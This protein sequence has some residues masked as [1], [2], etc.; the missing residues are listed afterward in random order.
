MNAKRQLHEN[1]R[2]TVLEIFAI[3]RKLDFRMSLHTLHLVQG[4][5]HQRERL[6]GK[7]DYHLIYLFLSRGFRGLL[8]AL[9]S[10]YLQQQIQCPRAF[11]N[12]VAEL[13]TSRSIQSSMY[14]HARA[15]L[16]QQHSIGDNSRRD[17]RQL[18]IDASRRR[19]MLQQEHLKS[20]QAKSKERLNGLQ[21]MGINEEH[22]R[23]IYIS[24]Y[25]YIYAWH[26]KTSAFH[27]KPTSCSN[28]SKRVKKASPQRCSGWAAQPHGFQ[29]SQAS[30]QKMR[31]GSWSR[32]SGS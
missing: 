10:S 23:N 27:W 7:S 17:F 14:Q 15:M 28:T 31:H 3:K 1:S 25:A 30:S 9:L 19:D 22:Q 24:V 13:S 5:S 2:T 20:P 12:F 4:L 21:R 8:T 16:H 29:K 32:A 11:S 26:T 18:A 6:F